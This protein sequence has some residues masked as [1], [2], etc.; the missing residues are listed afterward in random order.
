[1]QAWP[2]FIHLYPSVPAAGTLCFLF[3]SSEWMSAL[4]LGRPLTS[5]SRS[6]IPI[7]RGSMTLKVTAEPRLRKLKRTVM[8]DFCDAARLDG[9]STSQ[10]FPFCSRAK[11]R[12]WFQSSEASRC[13][14]DLNGVTTWWLKEEMNRFSCVRPSIHPSASFSAFRLLFGTYM[15]SSPAFQME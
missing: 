5:V 15:W 10:M 8:A 4:P 6:W 1:M 9:S 7:S 11:M 13:Y 12:H 3:W 14:R 2:R